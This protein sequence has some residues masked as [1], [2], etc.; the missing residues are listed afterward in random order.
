[1]DEAA[2]RSFDEADGTC[3]S[4]RENVFILIRAPLSLLCC[5]APIR[6][7]NKFCMQCNG[8]RGELYLPLTRVCG[9]P[10]AL[11]DVL[12]NSSEGGVWSKAPNTLGPTARFRVINNTAGCCLPRLIVFEQAAPELL[13]PGVEWTALPAEWV[14]GDYMHVY[15]SRGT[16]VPAFDRKRTS[17]SLPMPAFLPKDPLSGS[18][19]PG[20]LFGNPL[21]GYAQNP[22]IFSF[23]HQANHNPNT[24]NQMPFNQIMGGPGPAMLSVPDDGSPHGERAIRSETSSPGLEGLVSSFGAAVQPGVRSSG[25]QHLLPPPSAFQAA[26]GPGSLGARF[27]PTV[28]PPEGLQLKLDDGGACVGGAYRQFP[29]SIGPPQSVLS[30]G[31]LMHA[32]PPNQHIGAVSPIG[33]Q[34]PRAAHATSS[35]NGNAS[36]LFNPDRFVNLP[37]DLIGK[38]ESMEITANQCAACAIH[39]DAQLNNGAGSSS[40]GGAIEVTSSGAVVGSSTAAH[41]N[42]ALEGVDVSIGGAELDVSAGL[43]GS[44]ETCVHGG[45]RGT[46]RPKQVNVDAPSSSGKQDSS[47]GSKGECASQCSNDSEGSGSRDGTSESGSWTTGTYLIAKF[48]GFCANLAR[49]RKPKVPAIKPPPEPTMETENGLKS[50]ILEKLDALLEHG[51]FTQLSRIEKSLAELHLEQQTQMLANAKAL[52]GATSSRS[53]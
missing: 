3:A 16:L 1:M 21:A 36:S 40:V 48:T 6:R 52:G 44:R 18:V 2:I 37:A 11:H 39:P 47:T 30:P 12:V 41:A 45:L 33:H 51:N 20:Q 15:V 24:V 28:Q 23:H 34:S 27:D 42:A 53:I 17:Q 13:V 38:G 5:F 31:S 14:T 49:K 26:P 32:S 46:K 8:K 19:P 10:D 29:E 50:S 7:K 4:I 25:H 9:L 22:T 35:N 43:L